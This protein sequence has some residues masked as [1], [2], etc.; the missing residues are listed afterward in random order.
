MTYCITT[1]R[2]D[3]KFKKFY[4]SRKAANKAI[5][6]VLYEKDLQVGYVRNE[7]PHI[8]DFICENGSQFTVM[9][10]TK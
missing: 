7:V 6:K 1:N 2:H 9:R 5:E 3:C 10:S 4:L 8:Q